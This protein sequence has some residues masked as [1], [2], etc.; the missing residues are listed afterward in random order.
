MCRQFLAQEAPQEASVLLSRHTMTIKHTLHPLRPSQLLPFLCIYAFVF[1]CVKVRGQYRASFSS[2]LGFIFQSRIFHCT[3][4]SSLIWLGWL[5]LNPRCVGGVTCL[6]PKHWHD[7]CAEPD[8]DFS[9]GA[10]YTHTDSV[11]GWQ[12]L[13]QLSLLSSFP[14]PL[15]RPI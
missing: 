10:G 13:S 2:M 12:T 1:T 15:L 5:L 7:S 9:M 14:L 6:Y 4:E 3:P 11:F 8:V